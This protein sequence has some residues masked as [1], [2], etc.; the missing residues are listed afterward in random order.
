MQAPQRFGFHWLI[1]IST[2]YKV[3]VTS[4]SLGTAGDLR[5]EPELNLR[6][7]RVSIKTSLAAPWLM[8]LPG[9]PKTSGVRSNSSGRGGRGSMPLQIYVSS[10]GMAK[11]WAGL[12]VCA[13]GWCMSIQICISCWGLGCRRCGLDCIRASFIFTCIHIVEL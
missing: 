7:S 11:M 9:K 13:E 6:D 5:C 2:F 3:P 1:V 12:C 4:G 10:M 8:M